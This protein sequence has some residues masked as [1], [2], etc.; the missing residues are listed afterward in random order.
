MEHLSK[1]EQWHVTYLDIA[2]LIAK[3][4]HA[5]RKKTG[6]IIVKD[7]RI[8]STG[9]NGTPAGFPNQC[10]DSNFNT[11]PEVLH[12]ESNAITKCAKS[13]ESSEGSIL[14]TTLSPCIECAKLIIQ[15]GIKE[16]Y[17]FEEYRT[18]EGIE[19][20]EFANIKTTKI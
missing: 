12:A 8:I 10:E 15:A 3:H 13:T 16:V 14:Y 19:L 18:K 7:I 6:A 20:L 11:L 17:Y 4:S 2:K 9:Y 5:E 1:I